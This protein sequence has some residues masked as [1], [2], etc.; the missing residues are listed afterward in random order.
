[1]WFTINKKSRTTGKVIRTLANRVYCTSKEHAKQL[2]SSVFNV[3]GN[4]REDGWCWVLFPYNEN[5]VYYTL[6]F[7]KQ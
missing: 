2:A 3:N 1:M 5:G 7:R 4:W 6:S